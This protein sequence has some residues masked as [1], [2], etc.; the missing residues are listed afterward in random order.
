MSSRVVEP[1][2]EDMNLG[3]SEEP[4]IDHELDQ[5]TQSDD[6]ALDTDE[7]E[8]ANTLKLAESVTPMHILPLYSLLP[9]AEQQRVF[10][11]APDNTPV[12][13]THLT[14]PTKA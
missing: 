4:A 11:G 10:D 14:L 12:S 7:E 1:E 3:T 6:D 9:T 8:D 5:D 2:A 13:Y